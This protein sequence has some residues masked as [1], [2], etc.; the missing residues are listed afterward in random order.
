MLMKLLFFYIV[1]QI[2]SLFFFFKFHFRYKVIKNIDRF[3]GEEFFEQFVSY[4]RGYV[5]FTVILI[6]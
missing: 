2:N 3:V 6:I 5:I 4:S 1:K